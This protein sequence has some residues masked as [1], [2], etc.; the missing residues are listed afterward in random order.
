MM[1]GPRCHRWLASAGALAVAVSVVSR[2]PAPVAAQTRSATT[3]TTTTKT[4]NAPLTADGQVDLEGVWD[5]S[6]ITPLER[7]GDVKDKQK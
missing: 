1:E 2:S 6:T 4:W 7:P 3:T 5:F